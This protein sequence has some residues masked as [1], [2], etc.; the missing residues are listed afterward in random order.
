[1]LPSCAVPPVPLP[2]CV[3]AVDH[4]IVRSERRVVVVAGI[5]AVAVQKAI[6]EEVSTL[7]LRCRLAQKMAAWSCRLAM[8]RPELPSF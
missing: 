3:A 8:L 1:M 6:D 2:G 4:A 7:R 5:D